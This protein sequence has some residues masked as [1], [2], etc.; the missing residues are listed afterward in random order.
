MPLVFAS[1]M[2]NAIGNKVWMWLVSCLNVMG[3]WPL[4]LKSE[5]ANKFVVPL[6]VP[7][8]PKG[9]WKESSTERWDDARAESQIRFRVVLFKPWDSVVSVKAGARLVFSS[10]LPHQVVGM[11]IGN[12]IGLFWVCCNFEYFVDNP[13]KKQSHKIG[14]AVWQIQK[15]QRWVFS[16]SKHLFVFLTTNQTPPLLR[17]PFGWLGFS[18][19]FCGVSLW[20]VWF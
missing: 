10:P 16:P 19:L 8:G 14:S 20:V 1:L 3:F 7:I 6:V 13:G 5:L 12:H 15:P 18:S 11:E 17:D 9:Q 4:S 2:T